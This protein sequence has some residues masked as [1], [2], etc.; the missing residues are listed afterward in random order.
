MKERINE[1]TQYIYMRVCISLHK[2]LIHFSFFLSSFSLSLFLLFS[3]LFALFSP[4]SLLHLFLSYSYNT[5]KTFYTKIWLKN[6]FNKWD[7]RYQQTI[8]ICKY[9]LIL[10]INKWFKKKKLKRIYFIKTE[11]FNFFWLYTNWFSNILIF[12]YRIYFAYF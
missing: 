7:Y 6:K 8:T 2:L 10:I 4:F 5:K 9:L 12:Y 1:R 11:L 3:F